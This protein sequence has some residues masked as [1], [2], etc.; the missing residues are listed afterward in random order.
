MR[1]IAETVLVVLVV[2]APNIGAAQT[3]A[4][5][6]AARVTDEDRLRWFSVHAGA[7]STLLDGGSVVSLSVGFSPSR[8]FTVL[9]GGE[10]TH[11]PTRSERFPDGGFSATRGGTLNLVSVEARFSLR[12]QGRIAPYI[13]AGF[14]AGTSRPNV[15]EFFRDEVRNS[16][17]AGFVSGGIDVPL[18]SAVSAFADVRFSLHGEKDVVMPIVPVRGGIAVRF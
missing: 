7:G 17:G 10:R 15:N 9:V 13:G 18:G 8:R 11:L 6:Q 16:A 2:L 5:A 12:D 3:L 4:T 1:R 14:G